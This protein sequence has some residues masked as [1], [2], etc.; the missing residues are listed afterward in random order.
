MRIRD[1]LKDKIIFLSFQLFLIVYIVVLLEVFKIDRRAAVF[2]GFTMILIDV[3]AL[4]PEYYRK[5]KYYSSVYRKLNSMDKK[6]YIYSVLDEP[7]FK[8][9]EILDDIVKQTTKAMNDEISF[10]KLKNEEYQEYVEMW[11]HEVKIPIACIDLI[12]E[13]N[14]SDVTKSIEEE[15]KKIDNYVEQALFFARSTNIENDY[16]IKNIVVSKLVKKVIKKYSKPLIAKK[17]KINIKDLDINV[18]TDDKWLE[19]IISQII[20]NSLKYSDKGFSLSF[21]GQANNNNFILKIKDDGIGIPKE[22]ICRVF[23]KGFTGLNGRKF[24]K[25]TGMGLYLCK[26]LCDKLYLNIEIDS[27][28]N[29]YTEVAIIFPKDKSVVFDD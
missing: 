20:S 27:Q 23:S 7:F 25:S 6:Q 29:E 8:E 26:K 17:C 3:V 15:I 28:I 9:E 16:K 19:F 5:N 12:C 18:Y 2:I 4:V 22:D 10:Y 1:F 11:I 13:N 21:S 14:N 24:A